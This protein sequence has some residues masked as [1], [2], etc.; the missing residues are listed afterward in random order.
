MQ[1]RRAHST[2]LGRP[3]GTAGDVKGS[4]GE[5]D[6]D[7]RLYSVRIARATG[8]EWG[9]DISFSW[10]YVRALEPDGAAAN[11][12]EISVGDQVHMARLGRSDGGDRRYVVWA[13]RPTPSKALPLFWG[14]FWQSFTPISWRSARRARGRSA[15]SATYST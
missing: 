1:Q 4:G 13:R 8:I 12:G 7:P 10:V 14:Q 11:C 9:T 6:Q 3:A 2:Y 15:A 5:E